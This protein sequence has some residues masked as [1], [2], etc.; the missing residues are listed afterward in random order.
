MESKAQKSFCLN[1]NKDVKV[2]NLHALL[3]AFYSFAPQ[4]GSG[5]NIHYMEHYMQYVFNLPPHHLG[6]QLSTPH[7]HKLLLLQN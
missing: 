6:C 2:M 5:K 3:S 7:S 1:L 4:G